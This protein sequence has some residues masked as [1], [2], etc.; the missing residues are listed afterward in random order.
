MSI[1]HTPIA[2]AL[3]TLLL[4]ACASGGMYNEPYALF[5]P[6]ERSN[7]Q[8]LRP[9]FVLSIDGKSRAVNDNNEP[10]TPGKHR[11]ELSLPGPLGTS[12]PVYKTIEVDAKPCTRY[13][14]GA[15]RDSP[16]ARDWY[17]TIEATE[18]IGECLKKF[19]A[20]K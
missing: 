9:A 5:E 12:N 11:V 18:P 1:P 14:F 19:P 7:V 20:V 15:R 8:E 6:R 13:R 16:T 3:S 10:V 17:P 2:I 4:A